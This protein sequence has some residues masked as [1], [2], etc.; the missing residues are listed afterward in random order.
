LQIAY[1]FPDSTED[2]GCSPLH[3]FL[4]IAIAVVKS[5]NWSSTAFNHTPEDG[6]PST[7]R[8]RTSGSV[9]TPNGKR[10]WASPFA[11]TPKATQPAA[12]PGN[13]SDRTVNHDDLTPPPPK[14]TA[15]KRAAARKN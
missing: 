14:R 12:T 15:G 13:Q 9:T 2:K 5:L 4:M 7:P 3:A 1:V 8:S 10:P 6:G 11:I